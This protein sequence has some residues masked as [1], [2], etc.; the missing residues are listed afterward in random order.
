MSALC[1][2]GVRVCDCTGWPSDKG[3]P[4][5]DMCDRWCMTCVRCMARAG[6]SYA[7]HCGARWE[8]FT[9]FARHAP[10][11][12]GGAS[13]RHTGCHASSCN[14]GEHGAHASLRV[15]GVASVSAGGTAGRCP[16]VA[17]TRR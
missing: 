13:Y 9:V 3:P 16:G 10:V 11:H 6:L 12:T 1:D 2:G 8:R 17:A 7:N 15:G 14:L 5:G 4:S